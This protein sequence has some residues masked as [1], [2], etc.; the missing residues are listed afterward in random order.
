MGDNRVI[1]QNWP[2]KIAKLIETSILV[3]HYVS[4]ISQE[5]FCR[6]FQFSSPIFI[7]G[8]T[9]KQ[10]NLTHIYFTVPTSTNA[11]CAITAL[12]FC[13]KFI[14]WQNYILFNYFN[15]IQHKITLT[16]FQNRHIP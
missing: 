15:H 14:T 5:Q 11:N 1:W 13:E 4:M 2:S 10:C 9:L 8:Q 12:N 16:L 3:L 7:N 6:R